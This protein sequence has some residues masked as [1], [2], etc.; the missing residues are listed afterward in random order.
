MFLC[1]VGS[2]SGIL[3]ANLHYWLKQAAKQPLIHLSIDIN[4][5]A[6][7]L[8][9][10]YYEQYGLDIVQVNG[11]LLNSFIFPRGIGRARPEVIVFNPPYVPV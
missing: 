10:K 7:I 1:E 11:S 9:Q 5:D 4:M 3:S 6:S 8:S 2:G